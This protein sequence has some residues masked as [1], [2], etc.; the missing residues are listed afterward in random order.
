MTNNTTNSTITEGGTILGLGEYELL[1]IV[2][3]IF[4]VF[5]LLGYGC[6]NYKIWNARARAGRRFV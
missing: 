5:T 3:F 1:G 2:L 4:V 6:Y